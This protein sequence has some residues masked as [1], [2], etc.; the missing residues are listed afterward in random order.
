MVR[1]AIEA[2]MPAPLRR[3]FHA[4]VL[5]HLATLPERPFERIARHAA[6]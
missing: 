5:A 3:A 4:A 6:L 1:E 2:R